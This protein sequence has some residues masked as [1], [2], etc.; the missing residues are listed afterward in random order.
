VS[1]GAGPELLG[2]GD[3]DADVEHRTH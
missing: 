2:A 1:L 3:G